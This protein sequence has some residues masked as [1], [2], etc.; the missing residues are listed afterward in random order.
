[1]RK[2]LTVLTV[3]VLLG[4]ASAAQANVTSVSVTGGSL[5]VVGSPGADTPTLQ[6]LNPANG[7]SPGYTRIVDGGGVP[8]SVS[9]PCQKTAPA[10]QSAAANAVW[11]QDGGSAADLPSVTLSLGAGDDQPTL[12]EC[13]TT[14]TVDLAEG[15]N[16]YV[17][18]NCAGGTLNFSSGSGPDT[19][20]APA[21]TATNVTATLG[22]GDDSASGGG[23][24][25][26][27]D[28]GPGADYLVGGAGNDTLHGGADGDALLAGAGND[29]LEGGDG[30]DSFDQSRGVSND[31][32][33]G[34]DDYR[35]GAG[36]D[37][38]YL[39]A[40]PAGMII[41][42]DDVAN[43]GSP[44]ESDNLHADLED[45]RGTIKGDNY[46]GTAGP[47][48]FDGAAGDDVIHGGDGADTLF[49]GADGDT[50]YGDAGDDAVYGDYGNDTVDGG[51]GKDNIFGDLADCSSA[52][53]PAYNDTILARDGEAD[54]IQCGAGADSAQVDLVDVV[55]QDGFQL[56]ESVDRPALAVLPVPSPGGVLAGPS[57][58]PAPIPASYKT[59]GMPSITKGAKITVTCPAACTFTARLGLSAAAA[60][61]RGLGKKALTIGA[62]KGT[63]L[64]AGSRTVTINV[65]KKA[66]AKLKKVKSLRTTL[67][68]SI[69]G[70][71]G[72]AVVRSKPLTVKG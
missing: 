53:C 29:V 62:A 52:G 3:V 27:L 68:V 47:D 46:T 45:I 14:A 24:N 40:H 60:K 34:A 20:T 1:M 58:P 55:A 48:R 72:K 11:C 69:R 42:L 63:L 61:Q 32:G 18:P 15:T 7:G 66:R 13:F 71:I 70:P 35:G 17:V 8:V 56:C 31:P 41:S 38:V 6:Y 64:K 28:G 5:M 37:T 65:T 19:L 36:T 49:G 22:G 30:D 67:T 39:D 44:G 16:A 25:D 26:T 10:G 33:L 23:G 9:A 57:T 12:D 2:R 51:S 54:Q 43:D 59:R 50:V 21:A 4:A